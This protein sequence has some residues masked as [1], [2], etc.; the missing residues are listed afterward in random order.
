M[1]ENH[2]KHNKCFT[3]KLCPHTLRKYSLQCFLLPLSYTFSIDFGRHILKFCYKWGHMYLG[4]SSPAI[5]E[6]RSTWLFHFYQYEKI[7]DSPV[8]IC[9]SNT[10]PFCSRLQRK[11]HLLISPA[12]SQPAWGSKDEFLINRRN[13]GS[14]RNKS[15]PSSL[16]AN[17]K[18]FRHQGNLCIVLSHA[19]TA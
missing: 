13:Y 10:P 4:F 2:A 18:A 17:V 12:P 6:Y 1:E 7:W 11:T 5:E 14:T 16:V 15:L 8:T 9:Y 19:L 3:H